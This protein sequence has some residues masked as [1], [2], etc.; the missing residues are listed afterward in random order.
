M[1]I[2]PD[3]NVNMKGIS[4]PFNTFIPGIIPNATS[5]KKTTKNINPVTNIGSLNPYLYPSIPTVK[6]KNKK[7]NKYLPK[8]SI[9]NIPE[10]R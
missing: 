5:K 4:V 3:K 2:T 1:K 9:P 6:N 7:I 10:S 8:S